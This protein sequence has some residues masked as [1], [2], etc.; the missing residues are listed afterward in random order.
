MTFTNIAQ[1]GIALFSKRLMA[2]NIFTLDFSPDVVKQG[3]MVSTRIVPVSAA[4]VSRAS[5]TL[6][7][8]DATVLVGETTTEVKVTMDRNYVV[9]FNVTDQEAALIGSGVMADTKDK[10]IEKKVNALADEMLTYVFGLITAASYTTAHDAVSAAAF[11][12]HKVNAMRTKCAKA[13]FPIPG[14][15]MVL[16]PDMLQGLLD[17]A[18]IALRDNSGLTAVVDGT[19][20]IRR[21]SGFDIYE[22]VTL[23]T[24]SEKLAGFTATS[25]ALAVA[26]RAIPNQTPAPGAQVEVVTDPQTGATLTAY[27]WYDYAY[28]RWI[29]NFETFYGAIKANP[30]ALYRI[31]TA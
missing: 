27:M 7:Y 31:V 11:D 3:T 12:R 9:G 2:L 14:T 21:I 6:A 1:K 17:D 22:A 20:A 5:D 10:I 16:N 15:A 30:A 4:P 24:N 26:M 25:E 13:H 18:E 23:G 19:G 29:F 8:N 28:R